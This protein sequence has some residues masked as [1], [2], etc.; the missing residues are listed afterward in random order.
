[1]KIPQKILNTSVLV[2]V[3]AFT[4]LCAFQIKKLK[5]N[6]DFEAFFPNEDDELG[7]YE[8]HRN[9][10]EWDNEFVLLGIENK[11]GIF[12]KDFLEKIEKLSNE[13]K[14]IPHTDRIISPTTIKNISLSGLAPVQKRLLHIDD[15]SLYKDD[16]VAIYSTPELIGSFFP[17][18]A[19]SISIFIKTKDNLSKV[20]SD[21]LAR[22]IE[23]AFNKYHFDEVHFVGRIVAQDVYLKNLIFMGFFQVTLWHRCSDDD[24]DGF[25]ILDLRYY[26]NDESIIRYY[27]LYAPNHDIYCRYE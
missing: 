22:N 6:Y 19:K 17:K 25:Y 15:P 11:K 3:I 23:K 10:F 24:C 26:G 27:D 14:D 9:R 18:D 13:L 7:V 20:K 12:Q 21:S 16:S 1:M 8:T 4:V 5:F 2:F